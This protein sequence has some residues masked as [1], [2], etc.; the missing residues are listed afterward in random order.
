MRHQSIFVTDGEAVF[1]ELGIP[2][3]PVEQVLERLHVIA[4]F[5][6]Y[7]FGAQ[8]TDDARP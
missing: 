4:L 6:K 8:E 2:R 7:T 3:N 5:R 1:A